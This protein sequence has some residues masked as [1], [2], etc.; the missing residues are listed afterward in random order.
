M[1]PH[2]E[3]WVLDGGSIV[4]SR[5][6]GEEPREDGDPNPLAMVYVARHFG[7]GDA[8]RARLA[9]CAPE[10][11]RMLLDLEWGTECL[12]TKCGHAVPASSAATQSAESAFQKRS[13]FAFTIA[14]TAGSRSIATR[15]PHATRNRAVSAIGKNRVSMRSDSLPRSPLLAASAGWGVVTKALAEDAEEAA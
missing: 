4:R 5:A 12:C 6:H 9:V 10:M 8:V 11:A 3:T 13:T 15:T 2:E 7:D 14:P 1:R